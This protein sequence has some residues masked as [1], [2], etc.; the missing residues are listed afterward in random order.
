[1]TQPILP[2]S[3]VVQRRVEWAD[4]DAAGHQHNT[5][6]LRWLEEAETV[7]HERLGIA[8]RT[9]GRTPR[10]RI[11]VDFTGRLWFRD[12]VTIRLAVDRVGTSSLTYT[13]EM[14]QGDREAARGRMVVV[15]A[16]PSEAGSRP[17]PEDIRAALTGAG[18][19]QGEYLSTTP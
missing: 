12:I 11:E 3:V 19:Q 1:M 8:E 6:V 14:T 17:W 16:D 2:A 5:A 10:V 15:N 4:T 18:P 7:L 9:F 13:F